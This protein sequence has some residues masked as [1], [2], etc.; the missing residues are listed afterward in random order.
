MEADQGKRNGRKIL[1]NKIN[2]I[3]NDFRKRGRRGINDEDSKWEKKLRDQ[4]KKGKESELNERG[5]GGRIREEEEKGRRN[6]WEVEGR[7][8]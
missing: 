2:I 7:E 8:E 4:R 6:V 5:D 3:G 1:N